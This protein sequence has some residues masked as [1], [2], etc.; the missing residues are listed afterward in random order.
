MAEAI[1][2]LVRSARYGLTAAAM[3]FVVAT[4]YSQSPTQAPSANQSPSPIQSPTVADDTTQTRRVFEILPMTAS[5]AAAA[6]AQAA[7]KI[8]RDAAV[9]AQAAAK[10][11]TDAAQAEVAKTEAAKSAATPS[12]ATKSDAAL[13]ESKSAAV[14]PTTLEPSAPVAISRAQ[15][16]T[17][18]PDV[19]TTTTAA[20][21]AG[22]ADA[23]IDPAKTEPAGLGVGALA[24]AAVAPAADPIEPDPSVPEVPAKKYF[25]AAKTAAPMSARV[26][27]SY[28]KGC[29]AGGVALKTETDAWQAMRLSRNRNW[30]HPKLIGLLERFASDMKTKENW[31]GLLIGDLAQP[32]GGPMLTGH[33]SH[34]VGLDADIWFKPMPKKVMTRAERETLEP[35]LLAEDKGTTVITKNWDE[36][37]VRLVRR[38]ASYPEVER[39]FLHPAIKRELCKVSDTDRRW[40]KKV[41]PMWL[42]NYHFHIRMSCPAGSPGCVAQPPPPKEDDGCGKEVDDWIAMITAPPKPATVPPTPPSAPPP[43]LTL[44]RLPAQCRDVI[45]AGEPPEK[46]PPV[47]VA[48]KAGS[49]SAKTGG[50]KS[51]ST[52]VKASS[53][54]AAAASP[55]VAPPGS[56]P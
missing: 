43:V 17:T 13:S 35:L 48:N 1:M 45:T 15:P 47:V 14:T 11:A 32:R 27:G 4:A 52:T 56:S 38:A 28:A 9:E 50:S 6:E 30:G 40:L 26:F 7:A 16:D 2:V 19:A 49:K 24:P 23:K 36:G 39:I 46:H 18:K 25:G 31:P 5:Q 34:Q 10:A 53:K 33:K 41:R 29:L 20:L 37:F 3:V 51:A 22:D 44:E 42:H 54:K 21:P 12:A 55:S 8:A